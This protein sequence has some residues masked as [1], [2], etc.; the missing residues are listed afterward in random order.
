MS[1]YNGATMVWAATKTC[2]VLIIHEEDWFFG[3]LAFGGADQQPQDEP[4]PIYPDGGVSLGF[5]D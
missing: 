1:G 4:V 3:Q 2:G 5:Q